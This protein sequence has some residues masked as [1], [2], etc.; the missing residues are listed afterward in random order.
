MGVAISNEIRASK[1]HVPQS[2]REPLTPFATI[3]NSPKFAMSRNDRYDMD[4]HS[5]RS[6]WPSSDLSSPP[7]LLHRLVLAAAGRANGAYSTHQI[8]GVTLDN[9]REREIVKG[10]ALLGVS[11]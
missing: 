2:P 7:K 11:W 6:E 1:K 5:A 8:R 9:N 4:Q 3:P 10:A